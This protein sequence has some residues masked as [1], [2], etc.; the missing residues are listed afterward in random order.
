M[1]SAVLPEYITEIQPKERRGAELLF[2]AGIP[3]AVGAAAWLVID[4]IGAHFLQHMLLLRLSCGIGL[5]L[6]LISGV[7]SYCNTALDWNRRVVSVQSG[8]LHKLLY[9]IRTDAVQE[10]QIKTSPVKEML[11]LGNYYVHYHGPRFNNVSVSKNI[12]GAYFSELANT[13]EN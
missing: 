4:R 13:V 11:G 9:R 12:S 3:L 8:G 5:V 1:L 10:V 2:H 7:M 6:A